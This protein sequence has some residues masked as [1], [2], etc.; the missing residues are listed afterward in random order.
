MSA[1]F[2]ALIRFLLQWTWDA[3]DHEWHGFFDHGCGLCLMDGNDCGECDQGEF[4][5][6]RCLVAR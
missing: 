3:T 6:G 1:V 2:D 5:G 4:C